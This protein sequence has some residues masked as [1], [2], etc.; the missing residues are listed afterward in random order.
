MY[1][2]DLT[3]DG[4]GRTDGALESAD[5]LAECLLRSGQLVGDHVVGVADPDLRISGVL[6]LPTSL[7]DRYHTEYVRQEL[8][9]LRSMGGAP[10]R[11]TIHPQ[12]PERERRTSR[13][14]GTSTCSSSG[15]APRAWSHR[16]GTRPRTGTSRCTSS[17]SRRT[18]ASGS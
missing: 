12:D 9:I 17:R 13:T 7:D 3:F 18:T 1:L 2:C 4:L 15:L 8:A 11:V 14:S 5:R 6:P 10:L 16:S